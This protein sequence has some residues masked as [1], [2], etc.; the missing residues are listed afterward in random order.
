M[1]KYIILILSIFIF[2][3]ING[4]AQK[5]DSLKISLS[6]AVKKGLENNFGIR[7]SQKDVQKAENNNSW[8]KAGLL[9]TVSLG[10]NQIN[11]YDNSASQFTDER[12][13][14]YMNSLTPY[15]NVRMNIFS[16]FS[17]KI[18]KQNLQQ[19]QSLSEGNLQLTLE[20]TVA[21]I[22]NA[23]NSVLLENEKLKVTEDLMKLS[24]DRYKYILLKKDL[25]LSVT[26]QVLQEKNSFLTDS[27]N[28]LSQLMNTQNAMREFSKV[29]G[30][31]KIT[32][33]KLT[34]SLEVK[35]KNFDLAELENQMYD[36]NASL[37]IQSINNLILENNIKLSKSSLYPSLS[38]NAGAD[39]TNS[40]I[41]YNSESSTS[42]VYDAYVNLSLLYTVFNGNNR[43]RAI[44][45]AKIDAEKSQLQIDELKMVL[46]NNL[47]N[48][49]EMYNIRKQMLNVA[50]ENC[51]A[52]S[53]NLEISKEKYQSGIINSFNFRD[54]QI[55][56]M[57]A[58][59][60][61]SQSKY[62]MIMRYNDLL[63]ITGK[64]LEEYK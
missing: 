45:N 25:G 54:I 39:H 3:S 31:K 36:N 7:I 22:I 29:L 37:K 46:R 32:N 41:K 55:V 57:N 19:L 58:A 15:L 60:A 11:R 9:P 59:F 16:G 10:A 1:K 28:Y 14:S 61:L 56:Y 35:D 40:V 20:N 50:R 47:Y 6:V 26:Y 43:N 33:Y 48:L 30:D 13:E 4:F 27:S 21:D 49:Y 52:A 53:L 34:D 8:G 64:I 18:S 5:K 38:L 2:L 12:N 62:Y 44:A 51:I 42:Y 63:K 17:V 23:Y 24:K